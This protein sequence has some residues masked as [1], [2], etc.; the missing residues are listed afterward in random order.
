[1]PEQNRLAQ[2]RFAGL[3]DRQII[4]AD[5]GGLALV[6]SGAN[7]DAIATG[8]STR[9]PKKRIFRIAPCP[10]GLRIVRPASLASDIVQ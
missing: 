8:S 9:R 1:V 5:V 3:N 2:G 7:F 6:G 4:E 10:I